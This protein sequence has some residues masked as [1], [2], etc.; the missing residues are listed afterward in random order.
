MKKQVRLYNV[1]FP[2]WLLCIFPQ[3]WLVLLPGNQLID[4]LVLTGALFVLK[5]RS[6]WAVVRQLWWKFRLLG[7]LAD[8]VGVLWMM[9]ALSIVSNAEAHSWWYDSL[10]YAMHNPFGHPAAFLWTLAAVALAGYC[11]YRFDK[12]AMKNCVLLSEGEKR[13]IALSMAVITTPWLFFIPM[14]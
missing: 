11:I 2:I 13:K 7:F 8:F 6:K 9:L 3:V 14:Y 1:L 12:R 5:C 10:S 4:C